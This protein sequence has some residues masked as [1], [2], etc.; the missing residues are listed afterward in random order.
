IFA[1]SSRRLRISTMA[2]LLSLALPLSPRAVKALKTFSRRSRRPELFR[3][4]STNDRDSVM[5][6]L[7]AMPPSSGA[8]F[9]VGTKLSDQAGAVVLA[10]FHEPVLLVAK[11]MVAER[12]AQ[13][14]Q[15]LVDLG[16]PCFCGLVE[17]GAGAV[18]A[19]IGALQQ[20]HLLTGQTEAGALLVQHRDAA[21]QHC[22]HHDR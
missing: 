10:M 15:P 14:R 3:N 16:H 13:M 7:P 21:E 9:G 19:G 8:A 11:Q 17:A 1:L 18:E 2:S 22:V 6:A 12:G 20:P 4:G 5:I